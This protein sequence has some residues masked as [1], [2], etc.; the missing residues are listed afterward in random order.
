[1]LGASFGGRNSYRLFSLLGIPVYFH[2]SLPLGLL[3]VSRLEWAPGAWLGFV[4]LVL[5]H[6]A[7]HAFLVRRFRLRVDE[8]LLHGF[9]GECRTTSEMSSW[10][11]AVVA[12]GGILAQLVL[13]CAVATSTTLDVWSE[14]FRHSRLYDTLT[15]Y[16]VI[17]AALN[18]LPIHPLDGR[19]A[20]RLPYLVLLR[21]R[22][23]WLDYRLKREKAKKRSHL[24]RLH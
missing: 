19:E 8:I 3:M 1:M 24:R 2:V 12:W 6:E 17:L 18:L 22:L 20:W 15:S 14:S 4:V 13:F 23:A 21:L 11:S 5:V 10:Q 16:N 9:G 7:G